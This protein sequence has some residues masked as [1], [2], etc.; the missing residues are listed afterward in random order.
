EPGDQADAGRFD[1]AFTTG[2]LAG[3]AKSR[4]CAQAQLR[5]QQ[6]RRIQESIPM[7]AAKPGKFSVLQA[8]N[9]AENA[10]LRA[11]FQFRLKPNHVVERAKLVVLT[12]L[13]DPV[14]L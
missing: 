2:H 6:L 3:E 14:R 7:K 8:G 11:V 4:L 5:V 1:V 12:Q 10:L 9:G 13:H